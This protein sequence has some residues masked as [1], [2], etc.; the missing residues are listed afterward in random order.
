MI[1]HVTNGDGATGLI[2]AADAEGTV[3]P[4]R[5]VLHE[6]PVP[7]GLSD[8][9]LAA[10][11]AAFLAAHGAPAAEA[12][13][14][15]F[16]ERDG[17][18]ARAAEFAEVVLWFEHDLYDQLQLVQVLDRVAGLAAPPRAL[19]IICGAEYLGQL[20]PE[21]GSAMLAARTPVSGAMLGVA[22]LAWNAFTAADHTLLE[23][24]LRTDL[25][26]LPFLRAALV[27][28]LEEYPWTTDGL[29]R[30]E[31]QAL[32]AVAGGAATARDAFAAAQRHEDPLWCGD[33]TFFG[34][35]DRLA[36]GPAPLLERSGARVALTEAGR[37][38]LAG[39]ADAV[40]LNGIDRW[41]GGVHIIGTEA[42][43]R[44][45]PGRQALTAAA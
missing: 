25:A 2:R 35:L 22:R 20:P 45:D 44:W 28:L 26:P 42:P 13:R 24:A 14:R 16:A 12:V 6:G 39:R 32:L 11:R 41:L 10:V 27:R 33:E 19:T 30:M 31:R 36:A 5:D 8:E 15:G 21:R 17:A 23:A 7:G 9:A 40:R 18:L 37:G 4:W 3:I 1:L 38:V 34:Y 43:W 29:S